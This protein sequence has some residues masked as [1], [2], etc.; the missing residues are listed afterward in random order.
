[1]KFILEVIAFDIESCEIAERAGAHR[2]ELCANPAEGGTTP[3]FGM[4][5]K[6]RELTTIQ[7]FPIIRPRGGDFLYNV[8]EF[9]IMATDV[10]LCRDLGC[11]GVV[12]GM[13]NAD[14]TVDTNRCPRLVEIA[15]PLEVSFHRAFD[16]ACD[17]YEALEDVISM[18]CQ[19]IL[20]SGG[21]PSAMEGI[22]TIRQLVEQAN[23]R[24]SIMPGSGVRSS[25]MLELIQQSGAHEFHSSARKNISS[26]MDF[27]NPGM[28][29]ML[30]TISLDVDEVEE[31]LKVMRVF[32]A[33]EIEGLD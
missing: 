20:T 16:R 27:I 11:D 12:I 5:R 18:G 23:E 4:I 22:F 21:K 7:L 33:E 29:E 9:E 28:N 13:L 6:A 17:P 1:M 3:S 30:E 8:E 25:N 24:I 31:I 32:E 14:G 19:R 26:R 15:Y 10:K 2:I